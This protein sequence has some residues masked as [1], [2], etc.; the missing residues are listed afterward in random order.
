MLVFW[1]GAFIYKMA[2]YLAIVISHLTGIIGSLLL[3]I[4]NGIVSC[5]RSE[6]PFFKLFSLFVHAIGLDG[7][8][9]MRRSGGLAVDQLYFL[10]LRLL[11][12]KFF[13]SN[14]MR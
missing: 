14:F 5:R 10:G 4:L 12:V 1:F 13:G 7:L 8:I 9:G 3:L 2:F 11:G 6:V